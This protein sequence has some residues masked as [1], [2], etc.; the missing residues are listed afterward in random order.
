MVESDLATTSS[1]SPASGGGGKKSFE[2]V[3]AEIEDEAK[4]KQDAERKRFRGGR[5]RLHQ[6]G[7]RQADSL[8]PAAEKFSSS[9]SAADVK[10]TP[11]GRQRRAN[12]AKFS[13]RSSAPIR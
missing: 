8:W 6:H 2:Q 7:L 3:R 10:R 4:K 5:R 9:C 13:R 1:R 11:A 12:N